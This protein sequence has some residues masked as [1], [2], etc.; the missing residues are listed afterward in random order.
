MND[1]DATTTSASVSNGTLALT[2]GGEMGARTRAFDWSSTP[3]GPVEQWPQ[4]LRTI[5]YVILTSRH[6]MF[7]W[8]GPDLIQFYNDGYRPSL[9]S[10]RHPAALGAYGREFWG[11]IWPIIGPEI[12]SIMDGGEAT[13]HEDNL[14]PIARNARMEEVYWTYS[15]SPVLDDDNRV[16]GT[17]V[18]VQETTQ[19]VLT[20]RRM[21]IQHMLAA[22]TAADAWTVPEVARVVT[23]S[24]AR[25]DA[26]IPFAL[27]Y[28][29]DDD[30]RT[31]RLA[32]TVGD[33]SPQASPETIDLTDSEV[34][35]CG[36]PT[37]QVATSGTAVLLDNLHARFGD[38]P[39]GCWPEPAVRAQV[40]PIARAGQD[41]AVGVLIAGI[42]PRLAF[43]DAYRGF[44]DLLVSQIASAIY[45]AR[46][47]QAERAA[48][49]DAE[50]ERVRLR[51]LFE[52][53]P[54][55]ICLLSGPDHVFTLANPRYLELIGQT[56]VLAK[57]VRC[58]FPEL[59]GQ[60]ILEMLDNVYRTGQAVT[61]DE[62]L[63]RL[64][65]NADGVP[66][67]I[68]FNFVYAPFREASDTPDGIFVLAVEVT[69]QVH[70]RQM[71]ESAV[72]AR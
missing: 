6:P 7:L 53:A 56:D 35:T 40:L 49:A 13:W 70:L 46:T 71:T 24:L 30:G 54:A 29:R 34:D 41:R 12:E 22:R 14:V 43:D 10:D 52:Q 1:K 60:G 27:L 62:V 3:L 11:D 19:R 18:T 47:H 45:N 25:F 5:V 2:G 32:G 17:L 66:E 65:R 26:D 37:A 36:W 55:A 67:D 50:F 42:S 28:L 58:V 4:S 68:Y 23:E 39:G 44:H 59:V 31:L 15:Y 38:M 8:W 48:I 21:E 16:G 9:G 57:P 63:I 69:E 33:L 20:Q 72:R 51:L 64:D 61:G